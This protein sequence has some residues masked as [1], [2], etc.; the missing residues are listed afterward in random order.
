MSAPALTL[1]SSVWVAAAEP[2]DANHATS[3]ALLRAAVA[4]GC[5]V[6]VPAFARVEIACA[7]S[8]RRRDAAAGERLAAQGLAGLRAQELPVDGALLAEALQCGCRNFLRG[9]DA[10]FAATAILTASTLVSLDAEHLTRAGAVSPSA[11]LAGNPA[12]AHP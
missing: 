11:W 3:V 12:S 8:R 9:A 10:L 1:D 6:Y 2:A 5:A 7:L 4:R